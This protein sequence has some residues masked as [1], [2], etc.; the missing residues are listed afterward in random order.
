MRNRNRFIYLL[1][2]FSSIQLSH[3]APGWN[4]LASGLNGVVNTVVVHGSDV[5]VGGGFTDAGGIPEADY[6]AR[7]DGTSWHAVAAGFPLLTQIYSIAVSG[8]NIYV[9]GNF[10]SINGNT[11]LKRIA[12]WDGSNWNALGSGLNSAVYSI[13]ILSGNVYV[14]GGF[15][16]AGGISTANFIARWNGSNWNAV[17]GGLNNFVRSIVPSGSDLLVGGTFTDAGGNTDADCIARWNGSNWNALGSPNF[18]TFTSVYAVAAAGSDVYVGGNFTDL[19]GNSNADRIARFDGVDWHALG[20]GIANGIVNTL[21][22]DGA[23]LFVGGSFQNA[24]NNSIADYMARWTGTAW[25]GLNGN[26][27]SPV[28]GIGITPNNLY[29]GGDFINGANNSNINNVA[30]YEYTALPVELSRFE[31]F[32]APEGV[33]LR[34][35]TE[36][37]WQNDYFLIEHSADGIHF[38]ALGRQAGAGNSTQPR[39][40]A[41]LH[42]DPPAGPNYYRLRQTD[43]DGAEQLSGIRVVQ[44]GGQL[45]VLPN[46]VAHSFTVAGL[47]E[48]PVPARLYDGRG[49]LL[50]EGDCQEGEAVDLTRFPPGLYHAA[51]RQDSGWKMMAV[52]KQ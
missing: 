36:S 4:A 25:E 34:W 32:A 27:G 30:R 17:G 24:G 31:A 1:L 14:G 37:E 15:T 18:P 38:S 22:Y 39:Q 16:S 20:V 50:W 6:L 5:Y 44:L 48:T 28:R 42:R 7:W 33:W 46:P 10:T 3:A 29:V 8:S 13:V 41:F 47:G 23:H 45:R 11:N 49:K 2:L 35:Q 40:Y 52:F 19:A 43:M 26:L 51:I 12:R 21:A 9:G